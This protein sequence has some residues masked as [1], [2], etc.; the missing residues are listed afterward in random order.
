[1]PLQEP[2]PSLSFS[3]KEPLMARFFHTHRRRPR[4]AFTLV[5]LLV[6]IAIIGI[7][8]GLLL[9]AVQKVREAANRVKCEN[10]M[11]Q[12]AIA[13]HGEQDTY[14]SVAGLGSYPGPVCNSAPPNGV[15]LYH[16]LP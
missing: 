14:G 6:V 12:L 13:I 2:I 4:G 9:P 11:R 3:P 7:L 15:Y 5:E 8:I 1:M 16:I 10:N